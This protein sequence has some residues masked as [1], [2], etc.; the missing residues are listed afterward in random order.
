MRREL[1]NQS[2]TRARPDIGVP[3]EGKD[4]PHTFQLDQRN[5]DPQLRPTKTLPG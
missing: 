3:W 1:S 4:E 5:L 2:I